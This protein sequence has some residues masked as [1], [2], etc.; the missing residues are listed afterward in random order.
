[1]F[2]SSSQAFIFGLW[3]V[4]RSFLSGADGCYGQSNAFEGNQYKYFR[5]IG[6]D[7]SKYEIEGLVKREW[8][9]DQYSSSKWYLRSCWKN[10]VY[11]F[12]FINFDG[13]T[14]YVGNDSSGVSPGFSI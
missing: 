4:P 8:G 5:D 10:Y 1:M 2:L 13:G 9:K 6:T 3:H 7:A 14:S 12:C 11:G